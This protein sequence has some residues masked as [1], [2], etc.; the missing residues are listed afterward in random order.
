MSAPGVPPPCDGTERPSEL[1]EGF[2][3][4]ISFGPPAAQTNRSGAAR[5]SFL[6][7]MARHGTERVASTTAPDAPVVR[8]VGQGAHAALPRA[9]RRQPGP[10]RHRPGT[11]RPQPGARRRRSGVARDDPPT[12]RSSHR[13]GALRSVIRRSGSRAVAAAPT[14]RSSAPVTCTSGPSIEQSRPGI[15]EAEHGV[16]LTW[17]GVRRKRPRAVPT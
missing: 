11:A 15:V 14:A 4:T 3:S 16:W 13:A 12:R 10:R 8:Q 6:A 5:R 7:K 1:V 17:P 9:Q 2:A